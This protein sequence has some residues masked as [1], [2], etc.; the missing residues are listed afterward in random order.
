MTVDFDLREWLLILGSLFILCVLLHGYLRSRKKNQVT[1]ALDKSFISK[2]EETVEVDDWK[3]LSAELPSGGARP[4]LQ[5][6]A[7][8]EPGVD[9]PAETP[10]REN[11]QTGPTS[12]PVA[13]TPEAKKP[14]KYIQVHVLM[15]EKPFPGQRLLE[16]LTESGM[17]FGEMDIF[18]KLDAQ[19]RAEFSLASA[20]EP[21]VFELPNIATFSTPGVTLFIRVHELRDPLRAFDDL[22]DVA[23][24]IALELQ[25]EVRDETRSVMTPQT[26]DHYRQVIKDFQFKH[27]A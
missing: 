27:P 1:M 6:A 13:D 5:A 11:N 22:L 17:T 4:V 26:I 23:Q 12:D 19:G 16:V 25:G 14:E 21:G 24:N 7:V 9:K 20:V 2:P 8:N 15:L 3:Q 10:D 18:H